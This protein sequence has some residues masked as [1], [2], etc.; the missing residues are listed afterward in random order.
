MSCIIQHP[1]DVLGV[2]KLLPV[3]K[4]SNRAPENVEWLHLCNYLQVNFNPVEVS[5]IDLCENYK[6]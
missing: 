5:Q 2:T 3:I 6:Y 4:L 1:I